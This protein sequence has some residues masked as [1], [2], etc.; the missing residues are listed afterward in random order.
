MKG[1]HSKKWTISMLEWLRDNAHRDTRRHLY[2][3]FV[4]LFGPS[5]SFEGFDSKARKDMGIRLIPDHPNNQWDENQIN[6]IK[7][8]NRKFRTM[9][10]AYEEFKKSFPESV[11]TKIGFYSFCYKQMKTT[12]GQPRKCYPVGTVTSR[13]DPTSHHRERAYKYQSGHG[14]KNWKIVPLSVGEAAKENPKAFEAY[15]GI[16]EAQK[17]LREAKK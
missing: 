6:W 12:M 8:H 14:H 13:S 4:S 3:E 7:S 1:D 2:A 16:M 17:A 11:A 15:I 9:D 5:V 10:K